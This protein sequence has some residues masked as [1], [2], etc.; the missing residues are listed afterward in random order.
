M[1]VGRLLKILRKRKTLRKDK[2]APQFW[3]KKGS[4]N[5]SGQFN[6]PPGPGNPENKG[7]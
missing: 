4:G 3:H 1:G 5:A 7:L 6:Q 2:G